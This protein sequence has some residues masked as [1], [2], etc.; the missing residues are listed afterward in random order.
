MPAKKKEEEPVLEEAAAPVYLERIRENVRAREDGELL[1]SEIMEGVVR[2]AQDE[3]LKNYFDRTA[4]PYTVQCVC[5]EL[6][7][8]VQFVFVPRDAG[9]AT[10]ERAK[11]WIPDDEPS[12]C[13]TDTWSRG[14]IPIQNRTPANPADPAKDAD[15][16][17]KKS[18]QSALKRTQGS[19]VDRRPS[20]GTH[21][22]LNSTIGA[23]SERSSRSKAAKAGEGGGKK[24]SAGQAVDGGEAAKRMSAADLG[25]PDASGGVVSQKQEAKRR[26]EIREAAERQNA[27]LRE[28]KPGREICVDAVNGKVI[29]IQPSNPRRLVT[30]R[31]DMK[32]EVDDLTKPAHPKDHHPPSRAEP[33]ATNNLPEPAKPTQGNPAGRTGKKQRQ[34]KQKISDHVQPEDSSGPM[35]V[36]ARP[37]GGVTLREGEANLR[38]ELKNPKSRMARAEYKKILD[39]MG[40]KREATDMVGDQPE[41]AAGAASGNPTLP[42]PSDLHPTTAGSSNHPATPNPSQAKRRTPAPP[43]SSGVRSPDPAGKGARSPQPKA[44][45]PGTGQQQPQQQQQQQQP[46]FAVPQAVAP[47]PSNLHVATKGDL[48]HSKN[49]ER[50]PAGSPRASRPAPLPPPMYPATTGH[51]KPGANPHDTSPRKIRSPTSTIQIADVE[52]NEVAEDLLNSLHPENRH[53]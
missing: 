36:G 19:N 52:G 8:L 50:K 45:T 29:V 42:A 47:V 37:V 3:V 2:R 1:C 17:G 28:N 39:S 48:P 43:G 10:E 32:Y 31:F 30:K 21:G 18:G 49:R 20:V 7:D 12:P 15:K 4:I 24:A 33:N 51:G 26:A 22:G 38:T 53:E 41:P 23:A 5:K 6:L 35:V 40:V 14:A 46:A 34:D 16:D 44:M 9:D 11:M 25:D 27:Q 13:P